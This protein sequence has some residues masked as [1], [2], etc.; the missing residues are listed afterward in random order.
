MPKIEAVTG[1]YIY[2]N[3]Q[4]IDYRVYYEECGNGIPM[5][6]QHG[7][8]GDGLEWRHLLNDTEITSKFRVIVPDLPYHGKS[9]PP[10]SEQ[11]WKQEYK[12]TKSFIVNF[13]IGIN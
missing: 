6:C 1:R 8:A 13:H 3:I 11:W 7:G 9:L 10:E 12:L 5:I 4:N 2:L